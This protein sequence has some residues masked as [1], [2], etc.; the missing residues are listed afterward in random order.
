MLTSWSNRCVYYIEGDH[1]SEIPASQKYDG[2]NYTVCGHEAPYM[3][4][5][6][7][8]CSDHVHIALGRTAIKAGKKL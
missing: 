5:V 7:S 4:N 6:S 3:V 2:L 8:Y 1:P